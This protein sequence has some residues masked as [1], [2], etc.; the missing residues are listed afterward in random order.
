MIRN[1]QVQDNHPATLNQRLAVVQDFMA[2]G[3]RGCVVQ[4]TSPASGANVAFQ[5]PHTLNVE[6]DFFIAFPWSG[7]AVA[8]ATEAEQAT[9]DAKTITV[10][11]SIASTTFTFLVVTLK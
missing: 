4:A 10:H 7:A 6:P 2:K 11:S 5:V 3:L 9:W 8:G 1:L